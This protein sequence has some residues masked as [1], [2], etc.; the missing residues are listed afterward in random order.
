VTAAQ[1]NQVESQR[2]LWRVEIAATRETVQAFE[3]AAEP[4]LDSVSWFIDGKQPNWHIEGFTEKKPDPGSMAAALAAAADNLGVSPPAI[5]LSREPEKD[6]LIENL[7]LFP[8]HKIG[9]FFIYGTHYDCSPPAGA[10]GICLNPG[11]AFGSGD[12]PTTMGCLLAIDQLARRRRFYRPLDMGCG[13]GILSIAMALAW[14]VP[15]TAADVDRRALATSRDNARR[16]RLLPRLRTV[17]LP[18]HCPVYCPVRSDSYRCRAIAARGPFDLIVS[19]ILALPL[20][21][22][23]GGLA[24]RLRPGGLAVLGGF[25]ESDGNMVLAAHRQRG[26]GLVMRFAIE[27]WQTLVLE[28]PAGKS[29]SLITERKKNG[30]PDEKAK[31]GR[32]KK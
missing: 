3:E 23:A 22:M 8:P 9:R 13:S 14:K 10:L 18:V 12:H 29:S 15:V 20:C 31:M 19:N 1:E 26:L 28:R 24:R 5:S 21:R 16:N 17:N 25:L 2:D 11:P 4:F 30:L 6:W 32:T 27:G 7:K